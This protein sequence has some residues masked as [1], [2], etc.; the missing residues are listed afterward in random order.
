M[1]LERAWLDD[2]KIHDVADLANMVYALEGTN[3]GESPEPRVDSTS[4]PRAHGSTNRTRFYQPRIVQLTGYCS[5]SSPFATSQALDALKAKLA[6]D[7]EPVVL[8]FRR[9]GGVEDERMLVVP[10]SKLDAPIQG[11][12]SIVKWGQTLE[13][14][15][16]RIYSETLKAGA[17]DPTGAGSGSGVTFPLEF[18]LE[19]TGPAGAQLNV[20]NGGTYPT[21]PLLTITG[22]A[23]TLVAIDND[24]TGESIVFT[25]AGALAVAD[26]L[27]VDVAA[28]TVKL[29]GVSGPELIDGRLTTWFELPS[30]LNL[31]RLRGTGF[32]AGQTQLAVTFRDAR[33]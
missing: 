12:E 23:A 29:N 28:K 14:P 13:A 6:L 18:P 33:I 7:G 19:F 31:L 16:P 9:V 21:P 5:G 2:L 10:A 30:G 20:E 26:Q 22:P 15:D 1:M 3:L 4:R 8:K 11:W 25:G 32:V 17:Y 24:S 27:V